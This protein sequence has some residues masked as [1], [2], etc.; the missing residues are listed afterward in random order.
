LWISSLLPQAESK[1]LSIQLIISILEERAF[2]VR[3]EGDAIAAGKFRTLRMPHGPALPAQHI[4][5]F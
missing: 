5:L 2:Y 1:E 3:R 4:Y